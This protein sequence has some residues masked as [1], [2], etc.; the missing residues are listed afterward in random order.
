MEH[1][2]DVDGN[3][4][5]SL[6]VREFRDVRDELDARREAAHKHHFAIQAHVHFSL[7]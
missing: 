1:S 6:Q 4:L 2:E 5:I 3:D 7:R